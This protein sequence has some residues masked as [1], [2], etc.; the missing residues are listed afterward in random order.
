MPPITTA[1]PC[2]ECGKTYKAKETLTRHRKNHTTTSQYSCHLCDSSFKRKDLLT[3]HVATHE[4][5]ED[6]QL[7]TRRANNSS[8]DRCSTRKLR[9]DG[10]TPCTN[11]ADA[12]QQCCYQDTQRSMAGTSYETNNDKTAPDS[13]FIGVSLGSDTGV[14]SS[15]NN[16]D[17]D[18]PYFDPLANDM[19]TWPW[20]YE[21]MYMQNESLWHG[22]GDSIGN[23]NQDDLVDFG[24]GFRGRIATD[25]D[26]RNTV[27]SD[28]A[29]LR[30]IDNSSADQVHE[31]LHQQAIPSQRVASR[32]HDNLTDAAPTAASPPRTFSRS[33]TPEVTVRREALV[34]EVVTNS[35][36]YAVDPS[37][38]V[39]DREDTSK[40]MVDTFELRQ[41]GIEPEMA[42]DYFVG[43]YFKH[44]YLLWP[45]FHQKT[46]QTV[47]LDSPYLYLTLSAVGSAFAG[48]RAWSYHSLLLNALRTK[49][50]T[51]CF[52]DC[53]PEHQLEYLLGSLELVR[54]SF[55]YFGHPRALTA[56]QMIGG[57]LI[58]VARRLD[59]FGGAILSGQLPHALNQKVG[60]PQWIR[61]ETRKHLAVGLLMLE[62]DVSLLFGTRPLVSAEEF[63]IALPCSHGV[64]I[65]ESPSPPVLTGEN[66]EMFLFSHLVHI[67]LDPNEVYPILDPFVMKMILHG[68]Q[69]QVWRFSYEHGFMYQFRRSSPG[70]CSFRQ[71]NQTSTD[72]L[73]HSL[74][75]MRAYWQGRNN[76]IAALDR[77]KRTLAGNALPDHAK[78]QRSSLLAGHLL[79]HLSFMK[80]HAPIS[81]IHKLFLDTSSRNS[82]PSAICLLK[83]WAGTEDGIAAARHALTVR[84]LLQSEL[85][86]NEEDRAKF[87]VLSQLGMFHAAAI[88]WALAGSCPE[89]GLMIDDPLTNQDITIG[90]GS[91]SDLMRSYTKILSLVA[92]KWYGMSS[93]QTTVSDMAKIS[94]PL[95]E[96]VAES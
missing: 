94:F 89:P 32:K 82:N 42:L 28:V 86:R 11:C 1:Y 20:M 43:L 27:H 55:M 23:I 41:D 60:S 91:V 37:H 77:W 52:C 49:L 17:N 24:P 10:N 29:S 6:G 75:P 46:L 48:Q 74:R 2:P 88:L 5:K 14:Q 22:T 81:A 62:S 65:S 87:M 58:Y 71:G 85:D 13:S 25:T 39:W 84:A 61:N 45:L 12:E 70:V 34:I 92:L 36:E 3:R 53:M 15:W 78:S 21:A 44:F 7:R 56:T 83:D 80:I 96:K 35:L 50:T 9:C 19:A 66:R 4:S 33:V 79:F 73:D 59:L 54:I 90:R 76:L 63:G 16:L 95:D 38:G 8:C 18:V 40:K 67:A 47:H 30:N 57:A 26:R 72:F 51:A 68:L 93:I 69:D 31:N 64:W